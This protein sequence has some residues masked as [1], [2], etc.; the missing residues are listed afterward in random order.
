MRD[1]KKNEQKIW[2]S[3]YA[4]QVTDYYRDSD[5]NIIYDEIDGEMIARIKGDRPSYNAPVGFDICVSAG[6]GKAYE[7]VFGS[8]VDFTRSMS[9]TDLSLPID[10]KSI[11][12]IESPPAF[13]PD[14]SVD[15]NS[16]DYKVAAKPAKSLNTIL[17][18]IKQLPKGE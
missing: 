10:E 18:A 1:L 8:D 15:P 6:R 9:T 7:K 13:L 3:T 14:G 5:G 17:I 16:A 12:W 11:I 4:G 2:Y